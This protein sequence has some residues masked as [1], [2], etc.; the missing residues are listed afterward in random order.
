MTGVVCDQNHGISP[1]L[2]MAH[3]LAQ[4]RNRLSAGADGTFRPAGTFGGKASAAKRAMAALTGVSIP[5]TSATAVAIAQRTFL[6]ST[7]GG[8]L[9]TALVGQ[10]CVDGLQAYFSTRLKAVLSPEQ[11]ERIQRVQPGGT[12]SGSRPRLAGPCQDPACRKR[13]ESRDGQWHSS[14]LDGGSICTTCKARHSYSRTKRQPPAPP[15]ALL[16]DQFEKK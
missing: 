9:Q 16:P 12:S 4:S 14:P 11:Q 10:A 5:S 15:T 7:V 2:M 3:P 13:E 6:P 8:P 1:C